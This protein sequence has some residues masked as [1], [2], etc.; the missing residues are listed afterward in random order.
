MS[1]TKL[2]KLEKGFKLKVYKIVLSFVKEW[3]IFQANELY[4][5]EEQN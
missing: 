3:N 2:R 1:S 4:I 5:V